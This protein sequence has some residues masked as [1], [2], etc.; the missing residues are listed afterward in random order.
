MIGRK[1]RRQSSHVTS[2]NFASY[3]R[4]YLAPEALVGSLLGFLILATVR[5]TSSKTYEIQN[6]AT[7]EEADPSHL[8]VYKALFHPSSID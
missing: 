8:S 3:F 7:P 1:M 4:K 2:S 6:D 5:S